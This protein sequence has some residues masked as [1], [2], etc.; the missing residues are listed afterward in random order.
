M[1]HDSVPLSH[2]RLASRGSRSAL[3]GSASFFPVPSLSSAST[4]QDSQSARKAG[5]VADQNPDQIRRQRKD[6]WAAHLTPPGQS[7]P[8]LDFSS[9]PHNSMSGTD[10]PKRRDVYAPL[11]FCGL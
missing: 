5:K 11:A 7:V 9:E 3:G 2:S 1:L 8:V 10:P 6:L 4:A